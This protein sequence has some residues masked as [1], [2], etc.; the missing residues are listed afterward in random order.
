MR[1]TDTNRGRRRRRGRDN[2]GRRRGREFN[3]CCKIKKMI[4]S[5]S[6]PTKTASWQ[7]Q[8]TSKTPGS[9]SNP[10]RNIDVIRYPRFFFFK[11]TR[12]N[13]NGESVT[14]IHAKPGDGKQS[15]DWNE[16]KGKSLEMHLGDQN[17]WTYI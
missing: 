8:S 4:S 10:N 6:N 2:R 3:N 13:E 9:E 17:V 15:A 1:I 7:D 11:R 5:K 16:N 12:K 14:R